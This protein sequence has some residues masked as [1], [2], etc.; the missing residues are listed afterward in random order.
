MVLRVAPARASRAAGHGH[1]IRVMMIIGSTQKPGLGMIRLGPAD[2]ESRSR[3]PE[4]HLAIR[5]TGILIPA[6]HH[7]GQCPAG[8]ACQ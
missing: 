2:S 8:P 3:G 5:L 7:A 1:G 4:D 6:S